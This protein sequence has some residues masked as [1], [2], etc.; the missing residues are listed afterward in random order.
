MR[1]VATLAAILVGSLSTA[2]GGGCPECGYPTAY[3]PRD[4]RGGYE[5]TP[6]GHGRYIVTFHG[7][8]YTSASDVKTMATRRAY[9]LC[10][11]DGYSDVNVEGR[12]G[13]SKASSE[14]DVRVGGYGSFAHARSTS[15]T[16]EKFNVAL[17]IRCTAAA[18][19]AP[20]APAPPAAQSAPR[21]GA[22]IDRTSP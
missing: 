2:C 8:D 20:S 5:E 22:E 3:G 4:W 10:T 6:I 18:V 21:A 16:S 13:G 1:S 19:A 11:R 17:T 7:N 14:T 15:S 9:E 12:E